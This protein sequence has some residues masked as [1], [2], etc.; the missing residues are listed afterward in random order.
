[1]AQTLLGIQQNYGPQYVQLALQNLQQS[2]PQGYSAYK[3]LFDQIQQEASQN[4]P[5]QAL[6]EGTQTAIN[7]ILKNS[8]TLTPTEETQA[9]N[10][11]NAGNVQ[12]GII[13]GNAPTQNNVNA[14]V[15]ATDQQQQQAQSA[16]QQYLSE[17][18]TPADISYRTL[19]QNLSN[20][21]NFVSGVTPTSEFSS[22]SGASQ[23]AAPILQ[24][25]Y[26]PQ[27]I[28]ENQ[29][30]SSGINLQN[31]LFGTQEQ[32]ASGTANPYL[33]GLNLGIQGI[34][35]GLTANPNLFSQFGSSSV[36]PQSNQNAYLEY[37]GLGTPGMT[38]SGG[39]FG[40]E[41]P[42]SNADISGGDYSSTV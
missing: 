19:Q 24:T 6:S 25:G 32:L 29:A 27:G 13:L 15:G 36:S 34:S 42:A 31:E 21:G 2:D 23:G 1:M 16:A 22:L 39:S 9:L 37:L 18:V 10:Q 5:D 17:G 11:S 7:N 30:A 35:T 38:G 28:N 40:Y 3:Q 4:P 26:S 12:S 33:A 20:L 41:A 14:V 8:Q